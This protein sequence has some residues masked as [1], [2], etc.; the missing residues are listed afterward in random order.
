MICLVRHGQTEFNR[1]DRIQGRVDSPLTELGLAQARA[2]AARLAAIAAADPGAWRIETSPLGR[3]RRTAEIVAAAMGLPE[4]AVD[5]RLIEVSYGEVDGLTRTE[6]D[7]LWPQLAG[8]DSLFGRAPGGETYDSLRTRVAS[9]LGEAVRGEARVVVVTHAG[10]SRMM[11]G[12]Y[13]GLD[14]PAVR[15][16]EKPQDVIFRLDAG[17]AERIDCPPLPSLIP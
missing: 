15:A 4:P 12:L 9:W 3:A 11:R 13:L 17:R 8:L 16:L 6:A 7:A 5:E 14:E 2:I 1:E 10:V